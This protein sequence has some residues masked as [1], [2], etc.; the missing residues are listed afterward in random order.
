MGFI[1]TI[2]YLILFSLENV[3]QQLWEIRIKA[4]ISSNYLMSNSILSRQRNTTH[5]R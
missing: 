5:V 1:I 4:F 3:M 2:Y